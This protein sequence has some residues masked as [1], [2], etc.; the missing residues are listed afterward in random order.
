MIPEPE[1]FMEDRRREEKVAKKVK[2]ATGGG[3]HQRAAPG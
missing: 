2:G 3:E 1:P